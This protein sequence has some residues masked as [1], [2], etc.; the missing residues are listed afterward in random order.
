MEEIVK[1]PTT[2]YQKRYYTVEEYL[3]MENASQE[4]HEY[5]RGEIFPLNREVSV[6]GIN[7]MSGAGFTHNLLFSNIFV[8]LGV[9]LK[10]SKCTPFGSDM[11][12]NIPDNTL[13][14]YPDISVYCN[15][16]KHLDN[17]E[18]TNLFPTVIIEILSPSTKNYDRGDKFKLYRD[19]PTLKEYIL[20]DSECVSIEA[21]HINK[22][23]NWELKEYKNLDEQLNF[24]SLGF[25]IPLREIYD[26]VRFEA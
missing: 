2:A 9:K 21:F 5:F 22:K 4:K 3:E 13:F 11:R 26:H 20:V 24:V 25:E 18:N 7:L 17:D 15:D 10:G 23:Q 1:E 14:T 19:I 8:Q 12:L 6:E 16:I